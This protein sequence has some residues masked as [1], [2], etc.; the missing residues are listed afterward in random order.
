MKTY[1]L[2]VLRISILNSRTECNLKAKQSYRNVK[3]G[4]SGEEKVMKYLEE[5]RLTSKVEIY[6]N[7]VLDHVQIDVIVVTPKLICILEVKNISRNNF[8][9]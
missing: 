3:A 2:S 8:I 5:A 4:F 9:G 6:R 1:E 7:V